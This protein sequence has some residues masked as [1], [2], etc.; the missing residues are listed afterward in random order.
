MILVVTLIEIALDV[1]QPL[2]VQARGQDELSLVEARLQSYEK[3]RL[4][5]CGVVSPVEKF[6]PRRRLNQRR[7]PCVR[8]FSSLT[9]D[10]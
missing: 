5:A 10:R 9:S 4:R 1:R 7:A 6:G 3:G 2:R 8:I